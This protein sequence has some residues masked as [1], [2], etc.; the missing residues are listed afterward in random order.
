MT[1]KKSKELKVSYDLSST[2]NIAGVPFKVEEG[3]YAGIVFTVDNLNMKDIPGTDETEVSYDLT[4]HTDPDNI[5]KNA[6]AKTAFETV[7]KKF[8][9][10]LL[11]E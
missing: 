7:T 6:K 4:V 3:K 8:V 11:T 5:I 9:E 2:D 10:K 1:N